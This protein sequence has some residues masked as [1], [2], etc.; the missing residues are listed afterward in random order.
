MSRENVETARRAY[1]AWNRS[2]MDAMLGVFH[3]DFAFMTS[4][5]FP[6][7]DPVYV[8]H[9]GFRR[10]WH[11]FQD[12]WE[13]NFI[14]VHELRDCGHCV[15]ALVTFEARGRDGLEARRDSGGI[16]TFRDGLAARVDNRGNW[17]EALEAVGRAE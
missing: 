13:A 15:L 11:D 5:V 12:T 6:G 16:W 10:F 17:K 9:D 14:S 8:G 1:E 3:P 2:D 4:G 7:L